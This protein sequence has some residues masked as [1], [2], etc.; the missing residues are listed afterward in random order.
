MVPELETV[1]MGESSLNLR[2]RAV[3]ALRRAG[4][5]ASRA[6]LARITS[7]HSPEIAKAASNGLLA[8]K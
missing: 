7:T 4:T 5:P 8:K 1:A 2:M 3:F 6:A